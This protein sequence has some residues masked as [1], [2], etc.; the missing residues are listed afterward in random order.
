MT[1]LPERF[2]PAEDDDK[3]D[4]DDEAYIGGLAKNMH[5][6]KRAELTGRG[7]ADK[8]AVVGVKD[9]DSGKLTARPKAMSGRRLT[10]ADLTGE[11]K[12]VPVGEP[13]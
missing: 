4:N 2:D 5:A 13:F 8:A 9:R 11:R 10:W 1:D 6:R 3:D 7:G 12:P